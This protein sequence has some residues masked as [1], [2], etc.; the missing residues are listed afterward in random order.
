MWMRLNHNLLIGTSLSLALLASACGSVSKIPVVGQVASGDV[1][2][3]LD[4]LALK[5]YQYS[6][7]VSDEAR[8]K[9]LHDYIAEKIGF[10]VNVLDLFELF[11]SEQVTHIVPSTFILIAVGEAMPAKDMDTVLMYA[12]ILT[13]VFTGQLDA[14]SLISLPSGS[15][16]AGAVDA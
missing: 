3:S 2:A 13:G 15:K 16:K 11:D 7:A 8:D 5:Y 9:I 14:G 6:R 10:D 12:K 1:L 4:E